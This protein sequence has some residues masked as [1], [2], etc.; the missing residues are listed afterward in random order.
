MYIDKIVPFLLS[1]LN[2]WNVLKDKLTDESCS[3]Q[4]EVYRIYQEAL[5]DFMIDCPHDHIVT[6]YFGYVSNLE[7]SERMPNQ[8]LLSAV[9]S[10]KG[11]EFENVFIIGLNHGTFPSA[12]VTAAVNPLY[13]T[14]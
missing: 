7:F 8:V 13:D 4:L 12:K 2:Y 14:F 6:N 5:S 10:V 1:A 9:H 11:L 3:A